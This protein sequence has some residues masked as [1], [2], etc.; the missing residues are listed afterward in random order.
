E[1]PLTH[2][3][4]EPSLRDRGPAIGL[5][6]LIM[7]HD[8][9]KSCFMT[10]WSDHDISEKLGYFKTLL[11][12]AEKY[13]EANP[14][15]TIT[16]GVKP[17]FAHTGFGYIKKGVKIKNQFSLPLYSVEQFTEKP[18]KA[19]AEKFVKSKKHLWNSGYFIWKTETLLKL[20]EQH[21]PEVYNILQKIK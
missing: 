10:M 7:H 19:L 4:L 17:R 14:D 12:K 6:A 11:K 8:N 20:Y 15:A 3:S 13:L 1:I 2:Y 21:L 16:V 5:A 18:N 9:P